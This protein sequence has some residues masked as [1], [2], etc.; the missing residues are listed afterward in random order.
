MIEVRFAVQR[1]TTDVEELDE[2]TLG[3]LLPHG[4]PVPR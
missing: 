4:G 2:E 3:Q 1:F